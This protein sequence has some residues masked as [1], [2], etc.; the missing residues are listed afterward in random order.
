V[1]PKEFHVASFISAYI[2][3]KVVIGDTDDRYGCY[4]VEV[5][6]VGVDEVAVG[7]NSNN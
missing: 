4:V 7:F 6:V 5:L 1:Y 2:H 3:V